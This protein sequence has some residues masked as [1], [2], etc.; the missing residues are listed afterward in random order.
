VPWVIPQWVGPGVLEG[1][2]AYLLI[3]QFNQRS[4]LELV[5]QIE[6]LPTPVKGRVLDL[7]GNPGG[8]IKD[9][10]SP[11]SCRSEIGYLRTSSPVLG[12]RIRRRRSPSPRPLSSLP[13]KSN[14]LLSAPAI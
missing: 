2:I 12:S 9:H 6:R 4:L 14:K 13:P 3:T 5:D 11:G 7:R 1:A 10:P 8:V